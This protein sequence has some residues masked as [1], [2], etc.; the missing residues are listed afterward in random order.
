MNMKLTIATAYTTERKTILAIKVSL[1]TT[2]AAFALVT[3]AGI[4][5]Y[6]G[7]MQF[8][9]YSKMPEWFMNQQKPSMHLY[10]TMTRYIRIR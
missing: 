8:T 2:N 1:C 6:Y 4:H 5:K 7:L 9:D 10:T 3:G